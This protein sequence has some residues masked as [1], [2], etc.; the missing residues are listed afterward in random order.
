LISLSP[1]P[2]E[3]DEAPT[4]ALSAAC[5]SAFAAAPVGLAVLDLEGQIVEV[6]AAFLEL[7]GRDRE[8]V[9]AAP[10]SAH[11]VREGRD[12]V[13]R[14]L[15]QLVLGTSRGRAAPLGPVVLLS[16]KGP[17]RALL[18]HASRLEHYDGEL[19]GLILAAQET[20]R[21]PSADASLIQAQKMQA[22]GQLAGGIAHDF[23]NLLTAMIGF[24]DLLLSRHAPGEP[25]HDDIL[26]IRDNAARA[27]A[28][29]RQL[30]AFS[31]QQTLAPVI[32]DPTAAI[33]D[34]SLML[35][36]LLG[37]AI[38]LRLEPC[39][40]PLRVR[41]DAVQFDQVILNLAVN[42]RDAMPEGGTLTIRTSRKR[43]EAPRQAGLEVMPPDDYV[44]IEVSDTGVGIP[45]DILASIFEPFFTTKGPGAGTGLGLSTV[46]G[47]VR[48]TDGFIAVDSAPAC[49]STFALYLPRADAA[50]DVAAL[51]RGA[52]AAAAPA[53]PAVAGVQTQETQRD[54]KAT[55]LLVED[56]PGVRAFTLKALHRGGYR[57]LAAA[58][59]EAALELLD[60]HDGAVDL[61]ISDIV[62]P[63]MDGH[64][65]ARLLGERL[66]AVPVIF[67]S[68]FADDV[69]AGGADA[70]AHFLMKPFTLPE[71]IDTVGEALAE[72][73]APPPQAAP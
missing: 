13:E 7:L 37:P 64:T 41:V 16:P 25:S 19:A 10:F 30:L 67:I 63:G 44:C 12:E 50:A 22:V 31:R 52:L 27:A 73:T 29:V 21:P 11:V 33:A 34:L 66:G 58:D 71:L 8:A 2:A 9:I 17:Q 60:S 26:Q 20:P 1:R 53:P 69:V 70:D 61:L 62:M 40:E 45:G 43:T 4:V 59:G 6:N 14:R 15:A 42:A 68:G 47:I 55:V 39:G 48:Q 46:Y 57:V 72:R 23:N 49:G 18:L 51:G 38:E 54:A 5:A 35:S 65:L 28:L 56:E 36:R 3:P 32:L 24:S